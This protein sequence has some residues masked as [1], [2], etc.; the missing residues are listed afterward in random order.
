MLQQLAED[1]VDNRLSLFRQSFD[2]DIGNL[3]EI[4][5]WLAFNQMAAHVGDLGEMAIGFRKGWF[6]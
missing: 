5:R 4:F 3:A 6:V 2:I 1:I